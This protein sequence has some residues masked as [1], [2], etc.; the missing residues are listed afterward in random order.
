MEARSQLEC[1]ELLGTSLKTDFLV[2]FQLTYYAQIVPLK[3]Q[4]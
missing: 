2:E 4:G 1:Q 3:R